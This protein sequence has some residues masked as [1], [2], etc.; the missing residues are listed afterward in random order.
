MI[1]H[2]A[3]MYEASCGQPFAAV[4]VFSGNGELL[5]KA[6]GHDAFTSRE[7][8]PV[9]S[10]NHVTR[11]L[12]RQGGKYLKRLPLIQGAEFDA[13]WRAQVQN[14]VRTAQ[15]LKAADKLSEAA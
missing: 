9:F 3:F 5:C 15:L 8:A 7:F 1:N 11:W 2:K 4:F 13:S 14:W 6:F 10:V 12:A